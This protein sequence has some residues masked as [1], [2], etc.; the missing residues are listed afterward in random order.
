[1]A[2]LAVAPHLWEWADRE[3]RLDELIVGLWQQLSTHASVE[4]P[5]CGSAMEPEY[6]AHALPVG[7]RCGSCGSS[8]E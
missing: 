5:V 4:C 8:L 2:T 6:G 1:V 7:G 3:P